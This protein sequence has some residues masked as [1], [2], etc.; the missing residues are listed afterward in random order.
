MRVP[1]A[2]VCFGVSLRRGVP[3]AAHWRR[4]LGRSIRVVPRT[5]EETGDEVPVAGVRGGDWVS[6]RMG[7]A[8]QC[9]EAL[10]AGAQAAL[11][12]MLLVRN[13]MPRDSRWGRARKN[14]RRD[15]SAIRDRYDA[16]RR[17]D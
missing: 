13:Q 9:A 12:M 17:D 4:F 11:R 16:A 3:D 5:G 7:Q 2:A 10:G 8:E 14:C 1:W 15:R 6:R